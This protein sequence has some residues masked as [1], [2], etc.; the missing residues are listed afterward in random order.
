MELPC[1]SPSDT[2]EDFQAIRGFEDY[3]D[4]VQSPAEAKSRAEQQAPTQLVVSDK[5]VRPCEDVQQVTPVSA[6]DLGW[7]AALMA[8]FKGSGLQ[9]SPEGHFRGLEDC[10]EEDE[11][12]Q[13]RASQAGSYREPEDYGDSEEDEDEEEEEEEE[14]ER[15]SL[16]GSY[17]EPEDY[18]DSEEE[19]GEA[20]GHGRS[21][22][23]YG[24]PGEYGDNAGKHAAESYGLRPKEEVCCETQAE[25][26]AVCVRVGCVCVGVWDGRW[27][28]G[29][30]GRADMHWQGWLCCVGQQGFNLGCV[31][32]S[33][34]RL[35]GVGFASQGF[36]GPISEKFVS[37]SFR[38]ILA[39][40]L[41]IFSRFLKILGPFPKFV[42]PLHF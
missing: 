42:T 17:R 24:K 11:E 29:M 14:E 40:F 39:G 35:F 27:S 30:Q 1:E 31:W 9:A 20:D 21:T 19:E 34:A 2:G 33:R 13:E 25:W 15:A 28:V 38:K 3:D 32:F 23:S 8:E 22:R 7:H 4:N 12:Y 36:L 16:A 10:V 37:I 6:G 26:R 5:A 18:C 41:K